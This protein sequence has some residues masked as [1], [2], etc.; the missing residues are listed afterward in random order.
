M[1]LY[2]D[3][4]DLGEISDLWRSGVFHGVTTNPAIVHKAGLTQADVPALV[5]GLR[6]LGVTELFV[7]T[8]GADE[9]AMWRSAM[10]IRDLGADIVVK[11]P[12]VRA[13]VDVAH[14]LVEQGADVLL[15]AVYHPTQALLARELGVWGIAPYFGRMADLSSAAGAAEQLAQMVAALSGSAVRTLA[16]SL[17]T[18]DAVAAAAAAGCTDL[19]FGAAVARELLEAPESGVALAEFEALGR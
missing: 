2:I 5:S 10:A 19:T 1:S 6:E 18:R 9:A 7:Q 3:S 11:V 15:T 14:R 17:R 13:G 4:A 16:A 12:A 8:T